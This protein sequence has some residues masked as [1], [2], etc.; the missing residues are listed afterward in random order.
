MAVAVAGPTIL[1]HRQKAATFLLLFDRLTG[2][3]RVNRRHQGSA[4]TI[5]GDELWGADRAGEQSVVFGSHQWRNSLQLTDFEGPDGPG[6]CSEQGRTPLR[7]L[8]AT[9]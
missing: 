3:Q 2:R 1:C 4:P 9:E 5:R 7:R 6:F 8:Y